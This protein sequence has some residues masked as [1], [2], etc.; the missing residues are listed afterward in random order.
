MFLSLRKVVIALG[1]RARSKT[2]G[3]NEMT[4]VYDTASYVLRINA[5]FV[6]ANP[7]KSAVTRAYIVPF[8]NE[9]FSFFS[10]TKNMEDKISTVPTVFAILNDSPRKRRDEAMVTTVPKEEMMAISDDSS[11]WFALN[12][13]REPRPQSRVDARK[14]QKYSPI[15]GKTKPFQMAKM[16]VRRAMAN[17]KIMAVPNTSLSFSRMMT[18]WRRLAT[19][20]VTTLIA[21]KAIQFIFSSIISLAQ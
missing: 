2:P 12:K 10:V 5:S 1:R 14:F 4:D 18:R 6:T 3:R 20:V 15:G 9:N 7:K 13:L 19:E 17:W 8:L 11:I 21:A 16:P